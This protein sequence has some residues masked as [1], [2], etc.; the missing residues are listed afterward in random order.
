MEIAATG[1]P[2]QKHHL[3]EGEGNLSAEAKSGP[4]LI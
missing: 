3:P 4:A 1:N 2:P